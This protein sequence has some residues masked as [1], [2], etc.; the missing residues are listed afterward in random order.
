[1][2]ALAENGEGADVGDFG[3]GVGVRWG[4]WRR[5]FAEARECLT[6]S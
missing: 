5:C 4:V 3:E 2:D 6:D 1:M